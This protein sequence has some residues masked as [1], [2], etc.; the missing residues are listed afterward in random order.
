MPPQKIGGLL[1][2]FGYSVLLFEALRTGIA[3]WN[4][5]LEELGVEEI[6]RAARAAGAGLGGMALPVRAVPPQARRD[7]DRARVARAAGMTAAYGTLGRNSR[8]SNSCS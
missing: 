7:S 1:I 6:L 8:I 2:A 4:G 3:W 5:E